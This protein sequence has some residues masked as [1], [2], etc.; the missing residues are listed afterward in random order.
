M[1]VLT[2]LKFGG[3]VLRNEADLATAVAEIQRWLERD[4]RVV[5]V[6]SAFDGTTDRLLSQAREYVPQ[7]ERG[8]EADAAATALLLATGELTTAS[9]LT[10][11]LHRAGVGATVLSPCAI[12]LRTDGRGVDANPVAVDADAIRRA[13]ARTPVVVV[14]GFIGVDDSR[15]FT[16]LGRGGSDLTALFLANELGAGR[17]RLIKDVDGLYDR[18]PALPGPKAK[19]Y[20][21]LSWDGALELDGKIIQHKAVRLAKDR[22]L[23]FEVGAFGKTEATRVGRAGANFGW[24]SHPSG[25]PTSRCPESVALSAHPL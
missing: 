14:P 22:A 7:A 25:V 3:S 1:S 17:C 11:A 12:D 23:E 6:V 4:G 2:V 19:R 5:A 21:T 8:I 10:L 20:E 15:Q 16:L 24:H 9:L 13:L 18:D